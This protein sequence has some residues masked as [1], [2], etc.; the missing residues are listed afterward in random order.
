MIHVHDPRAQ[1]S[2]IASQVVRIISASEHG[3]TPALDVLAV[4]GVAPNLRGAAQ[5]ALVIHSA[6][7]GELA[8][9]AGG[10]I[11]LTSVETSAVLPLPSE[12]AASCPQFS[13]IVVG[14]NASLSL[15]LEPSAIPSPGETVPVE[16]PC[17]S[18]S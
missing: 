14:Q 7:G 10:S 2:V 11:D 8:L 9:L 4:L 12:V 5:R 1:W 6:D 3:T 18:R 15:L 16:E 17:P 13:A